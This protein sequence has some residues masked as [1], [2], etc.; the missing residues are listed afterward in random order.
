MVTQELRRRLPLKGW[1]AI[2][3]YQEKGAHRAVQGHMRE[4][5]GG[6]GGRK[7][8]GKAWESFYPGFPGKASPGRVHRLRT[9]SFEYF[10]Q[11]LGYKYGLLC[12]VPS[13]RMIRAEKS[14]LLEFKSQIEPLH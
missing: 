3:S 12:R 2:Y 13:P 7:T 5:Q 11:A 8:K 10:Q 6:L 1:L 14:C 9:G 4:Y